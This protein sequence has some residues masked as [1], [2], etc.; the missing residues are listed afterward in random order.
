MR[1][2]PLRPGI[3]HRNTD[4]TSPLTVPGGEVAGTEI[5]RELPPELALTVWQVLRSVLLWAAEVPSQ[6]GDLFEP[7]AMEQWEV[8]LLQGTFDADLRYPLAVIV[9]ELADPEAASPEQMAHA[10]LCVTEWGLAH[11]ATRTALAFT[12]AAALCRPDHPR[13]AWMAGRLLRRHGYLREA[14][15]WIKRAVRVAGRTGDWETHTLG[16]NSLG[17]VFY[18]A[19][20]YPESLRMLEDALRASRKHRLRA[21]EGEILHDLFAVTVWGGDLARAE[22]FAQAAFEIY[23]TG[24]H[25]LPALAHDVAVLWIRRGQFS[26]AFTVLKELPAF[27]EYPE[28]RIR[29]LASLA[30]TAGACGDRLAFV[31]ASHEAESLV[32]DDQVSLRSAPALVEIGLGAWDLGEWETAERTLAGALRFAAISG[33][34]DVRLQA[35]SALTAVR[36]RCFPEKEQNPANSHSAVVGDVLVTGFLT[37]LR[38]AGPAAV[39]V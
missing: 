4:F 11:N 7:R 25:R 24:H 32:T 22:G 3:V 23:R 36:D 1:A 28:E 20:K 12:E 5:V 17:N 15:Q 29:V 18:E 39:W 6:R 16:L 10:C 38:T 21:R 31:Q 30:R 35:E 13:Y 27:F 8:E 9:G 34:S 2:S 19:G 33:E 26:R 14:E 37:S